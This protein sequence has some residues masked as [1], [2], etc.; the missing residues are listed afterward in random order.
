MSLI[1]DIS[2][3]MIGDGT[4]EGAF[5]ELKA[6]KKSL[7]G[8]LKRDSLARKANASM[9]YYDLL[10]SSNCDAEDVS[11]YAQSLENELVIMTKLAISSI[12]DR[13]GTG[14]DMMKMIYNAEAAEMEAAPRGAGNWP[15]K[16]G[17]PSTNKGGGGDKPDRVHNRADVTMSSNDGKNIVK[18]FNN[19]SPSILT[20]TFHTKTQEISFDFGVK[21]RIIHVNAKTLTSLF[22]MNLKPALIVQLRRLVTGKVN[23]FNDIIFAFEK[24]KTMAKI[25]K[26]SHQEGEGWA[27]AMNKALVENYFRKAV[28]S[29]K[30]KLPWFNVLMDVADYNNIRRNEGV[31]IVK[32]SGLR[33]VRNTMDKLMLLTVAI[34]DGVREEVFT[35]KDGQ[36][37]WEVNDLGD[38]AEK[39]GKMSTRDVREI[40]KMAGV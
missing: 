5:D 4:T 35:I 19:K 17:H 16:G 12:I 34:I 40:I 8:Y 7:S 33:S 37:S 32:E 2:D 38:L 1:T 3:I 18:K 27:F 11:L 36:K 24:M 30:K 15:Q 10:V 23:F 13:Q 29:D 25:E 26:K 20:Y 31:D 28:L 14:S 21:V 22:A 9:C 6:L 39:N